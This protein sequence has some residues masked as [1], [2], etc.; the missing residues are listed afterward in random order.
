MPGFELALLCQLLASNAENL[1]K[2]L[3]KQNKRSVSSLNIMSRSR[4]SPSEKETLLPRVQKQIWV[5]GNC[6]FTVEGSV[7]FQNIISPMA[8]PQAIPQTHSSFYPHR[9]TIT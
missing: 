3:R 7:T 4:N 8:M 6:K 1:T 9:K 5:E 2:Q